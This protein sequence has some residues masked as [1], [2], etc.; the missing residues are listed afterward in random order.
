MEEEAKSLSTKEF[1]QAL[2]E[3]HKSIKEE[4]KE[5]QKI[6]SKLQRQRDRYD[7]KKLKSGV[8]PDDLQQLRERFTCALTRLNSIDTRDVAIK[9][10]RCIIEKNTSKEALRIYLSSLSEHPKGR[11]HHSRE[12]EVDLIG[13]IAQIYG[14]KLLETGPNPLKTLIRMAEITQVYFKDL[15]RKVHIAAGIS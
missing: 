15:T 5:L 11:S 8:S 3:E 9:E 13:Y 6:Q 2:R 14:D 1:L 7:Q 12:Q 4:Q 10:I